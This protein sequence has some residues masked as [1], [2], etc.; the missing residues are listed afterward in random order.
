MPNPEPQEKWGILG[1][2]FDPVHLG[3]LVLANAA[4]ASKHL[5]GVLLIPSVK[6]PLKKTESTASF[7]DR[8]A[9]LKLAIDNNK[10][11]EVSDIEERER[12]SGYTFDTVTALKRYYPN[13]EFEF[14]IGADLLAD[15]PKWHRID[16]LIALVP[17]IAISRPEYDFSLIPAAYKNN[18]EVIETD[19][20]DISST[21]IRKLLK[22]RPFPKRLNALLP[23]PVISYIENRGLYR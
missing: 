5:T 11:L 4:I 13:R 19:T 7:G 2:S 17:F 14:L 8:L 21:E 9:M 15:L 6:N 10:Q 20:P 16:E 1:G 22:T 3:H 23:T 18:I 12:L